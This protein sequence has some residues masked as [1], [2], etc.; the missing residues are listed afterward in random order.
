MDRRD[1][2]KGSSAAALGLGT[3]AVAAASA[4]KA[5]D[6]FRGL[7]TPNVVQH[8]RRLRMV[9]LWPDSVSGPADHIHR[10]VRRIEAAT[11]GR[12]VIDIADEP[13][14]GGNA[15]KSVITGDA[16][17]YAGHEHAHRTLHPA[18]SYFAGLPCGTGMDIDHLNA[19]LT[20]ASGQDLWDTLAAEFNMKGLVIGHSGAAHGLFTRTPIRT[21]ADFRGKHIAITGLAAE[22]LEAVD[23]HPADGV[24][25]SV[26]D[27]IGAPDLDGIELHGPA[28]AI[29]HERFAAL[30]A[31]L[32]H[33]LLPGLCD[34]GHAITL[35]LRRSLWD[36]LAASER[37]MLSA[38][39]SEALAASRADA[40][41]EAR[42]FDQMTDS[43]IYTSDYKRPPHWDVV[44][45]ELSRIAATVVAD[46]SGHDAHSARINASYMAFKGHP[47]DP[48]NA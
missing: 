34:T 19:W 16:D 36:A 11:N 27:L 22:V 5:A 21:R 35:G 6:D 45:D 20:A 9:C 37:I 24:V 17:L 18:F 2:L 23:A 14:V 39:A 12:W 33:R 3:A 13:L 29:P 4:A 30:H 31:A 38:L 26:S 42:A 47:H 41:A 48:A 10:F 15:F 25:A 28:F 32:P 44:T 7:A 1:F 46:L 8:R 43:A 40:L